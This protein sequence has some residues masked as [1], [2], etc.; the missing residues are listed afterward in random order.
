MFRVSRVLCAAVLCLSIPAVGFAQMGQPQSAPDGF[1]LVYESA[2]GNITKAA[3]QVVEANYGFKPTPDVRTFGQLFGHI[4]NAN[5]MIC[6][7]ASGLPNPSKAD[8]EK[9]AAKAD[10]E[11]ALADSF[12]FCDKAWGAVTAD[13]ANEP[14]EIFGMKHTRASGL[15]FNSAHMW[16]HYGNLVTYMRLKGMVPPSSQ[17]R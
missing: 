6:S 7:L 5:F 15:S 4:A 17:G 2:K 12:A 11:K 8:L 13:N 1:R 3:A 10:L 9:T 14:I 16:E